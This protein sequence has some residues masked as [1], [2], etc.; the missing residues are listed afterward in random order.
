MDQVFVACGLESA[1]AHAAMIEAGRYRTAG[2][3]VLLVSNNAPIPELTPGFDEP[4][5]FAAI[6]ALFDRVV[7][8]NPIIEPYHPLVWRPADPAVWT[9]TFREALG[10]SGSFGLTLTSPTEPPA[11]MLVE[12]FPDAPVQ[13]VPAPSGETVPTPPVG[14]VASVLGRVGRLR[15]PARRRLRHGLLWL[16]TLT[17]RPD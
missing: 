7:R 15:Q 4:K 10:V 11:A 2:R 8:L 3:R 6:A 9:V 1:A 17:F 5:E 12:L 14:P 13:I 16:R